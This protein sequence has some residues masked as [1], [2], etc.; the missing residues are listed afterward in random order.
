MPQTSPVSPNSVWKPPGDF[1]VSPPPPG[2]TTAID[3]AKTY[4]LAELIDIAER[5]N[6]ET[7]VVWEQAKQQAAQRGIARS[8]LYP[9]ITTSIL[10]EG[11]RSRILFGNVFIKQDVGLVQPTLSLFYT[12]FDFGA[13]ASQ[14][15][16]AEANL[17]AA[18]FSF[19][20]THENIIFG[21]S[22]DY[23][24]LI[25]AQGQISAAEATLANSQT[26]QS[27][28]EERLKNGVATLPD[29]LEARAATAQAAYDLE[30]A[31]GVERVARGS[32]AGVLGISP[33]IVVNVRPLS[34][35]ALPTVLEQSVEDAIERAFKQRPELL[36]EQARIRAAQAGIKGARSQYYPSLSFSGTSDYQYLYGQ[37]ARSPTSQSSG[38]TW[39]AEF[40]LRW[41]LF[42]GGRRY[43]ELDSAKSATREAQAQLDSLRNQAA[44]DVWTAYSD[45][46]TA[47]AQ[48]KAAAALLDAADRSYAAASEAYRYGV[49][50][51]LDVV[52]AERALAQARSAQVVARAHVL[53]AVTN[54]AF[55]TGDLLRSA[56]AGGKP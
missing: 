24:Q 29:V 5:N 44:V 2:F 53:T 22:A 46:Q 15:E 39:V 56:V 51:L 27:A 17:L 31:R 8:A 43:N 6:P 1:S 10:M 3:P 33:A 28:A 23:Y 48:Q 12:I 32:L 9:L 49:R 47:I 20:E 54:F 45:V 11:S 7:R 36:A 42:D 40:S 14:I 16:A 30:T 38:D 41:T 25:S 50:N 19:N 37:Q 34:E 35:T 13:R 55:Q 26:V 21:V 4:S 52:S 18:N